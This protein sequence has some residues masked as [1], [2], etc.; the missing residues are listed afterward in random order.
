[1]C[2]SVICYIFNMSNHNKTLKEK[3]IH[4]VYLYLNR[5]AHPIIIIFNTLPLNFPNNVL[6]G[7]A[8]SFFLYWSIQLEEITSECA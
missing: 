8:S 4:H 6:Q 3:K 1:M 7:V 5:Y 2:Y